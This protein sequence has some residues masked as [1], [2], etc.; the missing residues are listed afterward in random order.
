MTCG[1][2]VVGFTFNGSSVVGFYSHSVG[3]YHYLKDAYGN[4]LKDV[5]V[6]VERITAD[7]GLT[8]L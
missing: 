8:L 5:F 2:Y 6:R 4:E 1:D 7:Q 3:C